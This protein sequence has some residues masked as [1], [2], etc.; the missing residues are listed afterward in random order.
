MVTLLRRRL[1]S[2]AVKRLTR[3]EVDLHRSQRNS[4]VGL[5]QQRGCQVVPDVSLVGQLKQVFLS[6]DLLFVVELAPIMGDQDEL[7]LT[8]LAAIPAELSQR[9]NESLKRNT[10]ILEKT[11]QILAGRRCFL[12]VGRAMWPG[13]R[14]C[15]SLHVRLNLFVILSLQ[16]L[17]Q[18]D[19]NAIRQPI[20]NSWIC[21]D[22]NARWESVENNLRTARPLCR[23]G[24]LRASLLKLNTGDRTIG[25]AAVD[26]LI[27]EYGRGPAFTLKNLERPLRGE[28]LGGC[29]ADHQLTA[30]TDGYQPISGRTQRPTAP[31]VQGPFDIAGQIIDTP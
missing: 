27:R 2:R 28:S 24:L 9:L 3:F 21:V 11:P 16:A 23:G 7:T 30:I 17:L 6:I 25:G 26:S 19:F 8:V 4:R 1:S 13:I 31:V 18:R 10:I 5:N 15:G 29:R 22:T 20:P 14:S 12:Q